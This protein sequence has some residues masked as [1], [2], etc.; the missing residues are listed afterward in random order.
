VL[1]RVVF[2]SVKQMPPEN[3]PVLIVEDERVARK[4]MTALLAHHG[5]PAKA[6]ETAEE[7]LAEVEK[8]G[9][10]HVIL[11]DVDL[12]GMSGLELLSRLEHDD[13]DFNAVLITAA[14]GE[15]ISKFCKDHVCDY[16][17]KPLNMGSLLTL[18]G[19]ARMQP[20]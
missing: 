6:F 17:R 7:L 2:E 20:H 4:A 8:G 15:E 18:L 16:L 5:Y 19:Q 9:S 14:D 13:R 3:F 12:P 1:R 11:A 10:P